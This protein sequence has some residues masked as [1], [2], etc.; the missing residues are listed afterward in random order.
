MAAQDTDATRRRWVL[1]D[2]PVPVRLM[3]TIHADRGAVLDALG[4][5]GDLAEWLVD[6]GLLDR[7]RRV[8][9]EDLER[10][11][12]LRDALRRLA[13][14][15][16]SG[17]RGPDGSAIDGI[18]DAIA[19]VNATA[20]AAPDPPRVR[21]IDGRLQ[22]HPEMVGPPVAGALSRVAAEAVELLT[23]SGAPPLGACH[24]PGCV[25]FFVKD[26]PRREW[27]S[28]ACGNR[29]RVARHYRRHHPAVSAAE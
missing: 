13:G 2:E 22:R 26:H 1:P 5:T 14:A 29:A 3:N 16:T 9:R 24:G 7:K 17:S 4:T 21:L 23:D 15:V 25:L 27:C 6:T 20:S 18:D 10:A 19:V 11:R 12:S 28:P 8:T